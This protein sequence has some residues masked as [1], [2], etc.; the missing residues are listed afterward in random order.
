M[1]RSD[2]DDTPTT[3]DEDAVIESGGRRGQRIQR[4]S[5]DWTRTRR[6]HKCREIGTQIP[7]LGPNVQLQGGTVIRAGDSV[8]VCVCVCVC[9]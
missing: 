1:G 7:S 5:V 8:C 3:E 9:V 4:W 6:I 2:T